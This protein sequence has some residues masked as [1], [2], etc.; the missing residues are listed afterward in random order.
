M[1]LDDAFYFN[2]LKKYVENLPTGP[3]KKDESELQEQESR[4]ADR[5]EQEKSGLP[6]V[7]EDHE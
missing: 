5:E 3:L 6:E 4:A 1:A 7:G 2:L